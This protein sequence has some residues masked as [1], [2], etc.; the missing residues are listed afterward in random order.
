MWPALV[1][2]AGSLIGSAVSAKSQGK[3]NRSNIELARE[4]MAFQERMSSTAYQRS[5]DDLEKAGLNRIL[6]LG[7]PASSPQGARPEVK[8]KVD[9]DVGSQAVSSALAVQRQTAEI[10]SIEARTGLTN[11]Q[12]DMIG[13]AG[14]LGA[15]AKRGLRWLEG[16]LGSKP[17]DD[18]PID[19]GNLAQQLAIDQ[20][21]LMDKL[22][23]MAGDAS[24]SAAQAREAA[25]EALDELKF[26]LTSKPSERL[27]R[28]N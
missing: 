17:G 28:T 25:K 2:L 26:F 15:L 27:E 7:G 8:R 11:A 19:Y 4:Q 9:P 14:D 18:T 20:K 21:S 6:A 13:A 10:K 1:G 24:A 5:A 16:K 3:A 12:K 23:R 22:V